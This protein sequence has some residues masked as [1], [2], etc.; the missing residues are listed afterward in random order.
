MSQQ[1]ARTAD[2]QDDRD[3][4][5][6]C[7]AA[8]DYMQG[9]YEGDA[10]RMRRCLHPELAKRAIR[11]DPQTGNQ[12]FSHLGQQQMV[13]KTRQGGGS[14][15]APEDKRYYD[16][17]VLDVYGEIACARAE[18]YEY[19]DYLHLARCEGKWLIVNVLWADNQA[20]R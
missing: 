8:L 11:P 6:I 17:A 10:E 9:W 14:G 1:A 19:V 3:V 7:Q 2:A 20:K 5:G 18:S 4:E 12:R 15:D 13:D 16:V